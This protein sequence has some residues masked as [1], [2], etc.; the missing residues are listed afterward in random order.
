MYVYYNGKDIGQLPEGEAIKIIVG[1]DLLLDCT[2]SHQNSS[3]VWTKDGAQSS[4]DSQKKVTDIQYIDKG[5]YNCKAMSHDKTY[6]SEIIE[7]KSV[8]V[9]ILYPPSYPEVEPF[10]HSSSVFSSVLHGDVITLTCNSDAN[11]KPNYE[12][13]IMSETG[14]IISRDSTYQLTVESYTINYYCIVRNQMVPTIGTAIT[15]SFMRNLKINPQ[16]KAKIYKIEGGIYKNVDEGDSLT[17]ICSTYGRPPPKVWWTKVDDNTFYHENNQLYEA[18]VH[19]KFTGIYFCNAENTV[20]LNESNIKTLVKEKVYIT[21]HATNKIETTT[22]TNNRSIEICSDKGET[23]D[24]RNTALFIL[25]GIGWFGLVLSVVFHILICTKNQSKKRETAL[26]SASFSASF[27]NEPLSAA[28][29]YTNN[30]RIPDSYNGSTTYD[31]IKP[32]NL[33]IVS[34]AMSDSN[35]TVLTSVSSCP[36]LSENNSYLHPQC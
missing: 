29:A 34:A 12:W 24:S 8:A 19:Q 11:P 14:P 6:N 15:T 13:R 2:S 4:F 36:I 23:N 17:V 21:V 31:E 7:N 25:T 16:A 10:K 9:E 27:T 3:Y 28:S 32:R 33:S 20:T 35:E 5:L 1:H 22:K 18:S 30:V 26:R